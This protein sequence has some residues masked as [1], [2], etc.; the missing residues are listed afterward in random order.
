[1]NMAVALA[2]SRWNELEA[3][4]DAPA[5]MRTWLDETERRAVVR[6]AE[7]RAEA[8]RLVRGWFDGCFG[9]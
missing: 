1:M 7:A 2:A 6:R 8:V 3:D 9:C 5:R 4:A